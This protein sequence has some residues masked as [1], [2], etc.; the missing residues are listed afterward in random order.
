[1]VMTNGFQKEFGF[2]GEDGAGKSTLINILSDTRTPDSGDIFFCSKK[3][4]CMLLFLTCGIGF[5]KLLTLCF[6]L[7]TIIYVS[8]I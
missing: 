6:I 5:E 2:L 7:I 4:T 3:A 8:I 1:M